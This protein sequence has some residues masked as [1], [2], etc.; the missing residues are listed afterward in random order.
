MIFKMIEKKLEPMHSQ[1]PV[2]VQLVLKKLFKYTVWLSIGI[3]LLA[4]DRDT[5]EGFKQLIALIVTG[6]V[7]ISLVLVSLKLD[8]DR[9][10]AKP[11]KTKRQ[12][13]KVTKR[14]K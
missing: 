4:I 14:K 11:V 12:K 10:P 8:D 13:V 2:D 5:A 6:Y 7:I 1:L 9:L 3:C